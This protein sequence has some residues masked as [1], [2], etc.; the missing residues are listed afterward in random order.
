M[1]TDLSV[2]LAGE[3]IATLHRGTSGRWT[4]RY[5]AAYRV[6]PRATPLSLSLPLSLPEHPHAPVEAFLSN[7]LPDNARVIERW[8]LRYQ[9]SA[10]DV[11]GLVAHVG[12]DCPGAVQ[13]VRP[14]RRAA[15][16]Q[17]SDDRVAWISD[18][19]VE[20]RL[21]ALRDDHAAG[22][23]PGDLGQF[24]L[25][26]AQPK[27]ALLWIDG[28]WGVPSGR[29][30]TTHILKPPTGALAG[31]A[32]NEHFCLSLA[33]AVGLPAAR[34]TVARF[35]AEIAIVVER[36]DRLRQGAGGA[37]EILR[38]HQ[39]DL[40]QALGVSPAAKY[41]SEGGPSPAA[42]VALLRRA[43]T[44]P[45]EDIETFL[46]ALAF[47][48]VIAGPD[49]H[50]KN[51]AL[52]HSGGAVRLA[53]LYDV[54]SALP[55]PEMPLQGLK[56]AMKIGGEYRLRNIGVHAWR[57]LCAEVGADPALTL[58]RLSDLAAR[59]AA[60]TPILLE[61]CHRQNLH[62]PTLDR[63]AAMLPARAL[64]CAGMLRGG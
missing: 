55:W 47:N 42:I 19:E 62:H 29:V 53:P 48:W 38:V 28:R 6:R 26:G 27:T 58:P 10:R 34:S 20:A 50:A 21:R 36:Y 35:G 8:A 51:Y 7:L 23:R 2:W 64:A 3:E 32:E 59:I 14:E 17:G 44:S 49:A 31:Q 15:L 41:Q 24:S 25:A 37:D 1:T 46:D 40:C 4:M 60:A 52:L 30:P 56:L 9:V 5:D 45:T 39:E 18:D 33:Q 43:S 13:I 11:F 16:A 12:E 63:L 22:R 57:R 61:R 54:A